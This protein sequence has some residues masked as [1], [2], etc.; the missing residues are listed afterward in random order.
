MEVSVIIP[1]FKRVEQ[2]IRTVSLLENSTGSKLDF[3]MELIVADSSPDERLKTALKQK[4]GSDIIYTQ[5][6][7]PGIAANKNQGAR[8]ARYPILIFC[9]SDIEVQPDTLKKTLHALQSL[10]TAAAIGGK[11]FWKGGKMQDQLDRPRP[12]DRMQTIGTTT[13]VEALY[14]RFMATYKDVF[15]AVGGYD[16]VAFNMRGEGSDL[17]IRYWRQGFPLVFAET[18]TVHHVHDVED[19]AAVRVSHAQWG[20]AKDLLLLAYKYNMLSGEFPNFFR[21]ITANFATFGETAPVAL[22][23][24]ILQNIEFIAK[25]QPLLDQFRKT[26]QPTFDFKFLEIFSNQELLEQSLKAVSQKLDLVRQKAWG[27]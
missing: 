5:P 24:G 6:P 20:I 2:T 1:C 22:F 21:T 17:S 14:S 11:V 7:K 19:A 23:Q 4:F 3:K 15:E 12:E 9:D 18:I 27:V 10:K 13:Y 8:I 26:D 16:E 25:V